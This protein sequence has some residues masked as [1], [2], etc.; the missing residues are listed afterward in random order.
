MKTTINITIGSGGFKLR[1]LLARASL[2]CVL[3]ALASCVDAAGTGPIACVN[4]PLAG[5]KSLSDGAAARGM[6]LAA[7]SPDA[8]LRGPV[9]VWEA[10]S[11]A[12]IDAARAHRIDEFVRDGGSL[13]VSLSQDPGIGLIRLAPLLPTTAWETL[14]TANRH[15]AADGP[16]AASTWDS[17]MFPAGEPQGLA[18]SYHFRIRPF[19]AVERGQARYERY[20][21]VIGMAG[22]K[23]GA[24]E[25]FWTRP[26]INRDWTI[27]IRGDDVGR[28][29]LLITG[30]YGKGRVAILAG[31]VADMRQSPSSRAVLSALLGWLAPAT[32]QAA[33]ANDSA[34]P[35]IMPAVSADPLTRTL[36]IKIV[37]PQTTRLDVQIRAR[38]L[39]W[40]PALIGDIVQKATLGPGAHKS[41]SLPIPAVDATAYQALDARDCYVAR[42]GVLTADGARL[43]GETRCQF[44]LRPPITVSVAADELHEAPAPFH[45]EGPALQARRMGMPISC[46]AYPPAFAMHAHITIADGSRNLAPAA[47]VRDETQPDN[48][49]TTAL[50]DLA[51]VAGKTPVDDVQAYGCWIGAKGRDNA[52]LFTFAA[53][54]TLSA[55][56]LIG[57]PADDSRD[58]AHNPGAAAVEAD[59]RQI[60]AASDLDERFNAGKGIATLRF[61]PVTAKVI[62]VRLPWLAQRPDGTRRD[63]PWLGEVMLY[64]VAGALPP[65]ASG[66]LQVFLADALTGATT[67]VGQEAVRVAPATRE[68]FDFP[69]ALPATSSLSV[70]RLEARFGDR[71]G[72]APVLVINPDHPLAPTTDFRPPHAPHL[73]F[74]VTRGFRNAFDIGTGTQE[75]HGSW[76]EPDDSVWAYSRRLKQVGPHGHTEAN[77]LYVTDSDMRHYSTPWDD[78]VDGESFYAAAAPNFIAR[79]Q[80][81]PDWPLSDYAILNQGDRWDTGPSVGNLYNW[82]DFVEFD[83]YLRSLGLAGI[84]SRTRD[85]IAEEIDTKYAGP[86]QAWQLSRYAENIHTLRSAFSAAGKHLLIAGQGTPVVPIAD[87]IDFAAAIR[88]MNDDSTW[89]MAQEDLPLTTARQMAVMAYNPVWAMSTLLQWG[90]DSAI[91]SFGFRAPVGTTEP[92]LRHYYDRAWRGVVDMDGVYRS[93]HAYGFSSNAGEAFTMTDNDWQQWW[94][95]QQRHSLIAPDGPLGLG[96]VLATS[97]LGQLQTAC[98]SG[99]GMGGSK[100]DTEVLKVA[101]AIRSLHDAG[102]SIPFTTNAAALAKWKGQAPLL[103]LNLCDCSPPEIAAL[104]AL[105]ARGA[106]LA[107]FTGDNPLSTQ[108]AALFASADSRVVGERLNRPITATSTTLLIPGGYAGLS[109]ADARLLTPLLQTI[110]D[111]PIVFPDGAAGYGFTMRGDSFIEIEDWLEQGRTVSIRLRASASARTARACE[112]NDHRPLP[113]RRDGPDWI[114]DLPLRPGGADLVCIREEK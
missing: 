17:A 57:I 104:R 4:L 73:D 77:R 40:E 59:G 70:L 9:V 36:Q 13:L 105:R 99:G 19:D 75:I 103:I 85:Q 106:R 91:L 32:A 15:G 52:L 69:I 56:T 93:M 74:I 90:Y 41:V 43:L 111:L 65:P 7:Q 37:N 35:E 68:T 48:P 96:V 71:T 22:I 98:F 82:Q 62:R 27:R 78:F 26:L 89:G 24:D 46:Y 6:T 79:M 18:L 100:M 30:L 1:R 64:G 63:A 114:I 86:W 53:P 44:D 110:C 33:A 72:S 49:S 8:A 29:P 112:L 20:A 23:L 45:T 42:V 83:E 58:V 67:L 12:D 50:N 113:I 5:L 94:R 2:V 10:T 39:T 87:Q 3:L 14:L 60:D 31:S 95:L 109:D 88:G 101:G 16:A 81:Q 66:Q 38:L 76:E 55:V 102:V 28:S 108:A 21:R 54:V 107:A 84:K 51:A 34:A 80:K 47:T 25:P 92:T 61:A 97:P 11:A